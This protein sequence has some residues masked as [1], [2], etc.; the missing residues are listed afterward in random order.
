[1]S[2]GSFLKFILVLTLSESQTKKHLACGGVELF[3]R[4]DKN[5]IL[6]FWN[7]QQWEGSSDVY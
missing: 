2:F 5:D 1:L 6:V 7:D 3:G 4:V